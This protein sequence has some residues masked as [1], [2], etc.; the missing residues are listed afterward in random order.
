VEYL[1]ELT[2]RA[3]R[4]LAAIYEYIHAESSEQAFEWFNGLEAAILS[5]AS[6]PERG[7]RTRENPVLRQLLY[8][9]KP[10][11]YRVIYRVQ[12]RA[13]KVRGVHIRHGARG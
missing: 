2:A 10:H 12:Q 11:V 9:N 8:G 6:Q 5:L 3:A 4:D 7:M 1:V 13:G